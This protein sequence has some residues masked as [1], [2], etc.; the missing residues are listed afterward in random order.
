MSSHRRLAINKINEIRFNFNTKKQ[1][2]INFDFTEILYLICNNLLDDVER[3][4]CVADYPKGQC[5][6]C[7]CPTCHRPK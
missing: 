2:E 6:R 7:E 4:G 5:T 1:D 3:C